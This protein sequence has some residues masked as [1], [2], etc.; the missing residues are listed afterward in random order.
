MFL[1]YF[2]LAL[3]FF[4]VFSVFYAVIV[5]HYSPYKI[6]NKRNHPYPDNILG[7]T[8]NTK[9]ITSSPTITKQVLLAKIL[10]GERSKATCMI[11]IN[12]DHVNVMRKILISMKSWQNYIYLD[13]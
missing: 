9:A 2:A 1:D 10:R 7:N 4:V 3:L 6:A 8:F 12:F 13:H 5:I 11:Q